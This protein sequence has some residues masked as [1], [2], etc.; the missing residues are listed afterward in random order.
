M[1]QFCFASILLM[2]GIGAN[3]LFFKGFAKST[4]TMDVVTSA[5]LLFI[6][7][8]SARTPGAPLLEQP[9]LV[10]IPSQPA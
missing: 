3:A 9:V 5:F 8:F 7:P 1:M 6:P 4:R 2:R 10:K